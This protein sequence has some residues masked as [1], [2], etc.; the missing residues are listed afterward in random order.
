MGFLLG[1]LVGAMIFG[2]MRR[3]RWRHGHGWGH[4]LG[5]HRWGGFG[6]RGHLRRGWWVLREL[7]LDPRQKDE[8]GALWL[9]ARR[10]IGEAQLARWRSMSDVADAAVADPLDP[11]RLEELATR[12]ADTQSKLARDV[13]SAIARLHEILRPEQRARLRELIE[14]AGLWR[15]SSSP[16]GAPPSDGPYR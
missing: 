12:H 6:C 10:A 9:S 15:F 4:R 2:V 13:T 11:A 14:R 7:D 1:I 16:A 3:R 5:H 8:L